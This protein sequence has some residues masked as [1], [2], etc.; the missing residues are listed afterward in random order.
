MSDYTILIIDYEPRSIERA[1]RPL[2]DAGYRVEVAKDGLAGLAAFKEL[3]P[4]LVLIEAMIPKKHGF[5]VCQEIK[6][7]PAG[8]QTPVII[9][10]AVYK[11]RK[12]R[13]QALH[14]YKCDEYVEKP[15]AEEDLMAIC[16]RHLGSKAGTVAAK[17]AP[18]EEVVQEPIRQA[19]REPEPEAALPSE[20]PADDGPDD[21]SA[22]DWAGNAEEEILA[23]LDAILT[24][25]AAGKPHKAAAA[26]PATSSD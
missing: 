9:C 2:T 23:Q 20:E 4:D 25:E 19:A 12:Y 16:L 24:D 18:V 10:T 8:N 26:G 14:L 3:E 5:E 13:T 6:K 21:L 11:G 15:I 22:A 7:T 1:R 17:Q